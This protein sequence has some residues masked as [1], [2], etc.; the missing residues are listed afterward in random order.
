MV[1]WPM[2]CWWE[3]LVYAVMFLKLR[4]RRQQGGNIRDVVALQILLD[5]ETSSDSDVAEES[6]D[7]GEDPGEIGGDFWIG[8]DWLNQMD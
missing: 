6:S 7:S 4:I 2:T 1:P 5:E 3:N 8:T